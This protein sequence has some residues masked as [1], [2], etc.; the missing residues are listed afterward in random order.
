MVEWYPVEAKW[1]WSIFKITKN[2]Y[3]WC[4]RKAWAFSVQNFTMWQ[5]ATIEITLILLVH[6]TYKWVL[7]FM[8][9]SFMVN[10]TFNTMPT[11][12]LQP[13]LSP[14][15]GFNGPSSRKQS[16]KPPQIEIWNTINEWNYHFQNVKPTCT[17]VKLPIKDFLMTV[18]VATHDNLHENNRK[19]WT[20]E[21]NYKM[22]IICSVLKKATGIWKPS[23]QPVVCRNIHRNY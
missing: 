15:E 6:V 14:R 20:P 10:R 13:V 17:N 8:R 16:S 4:N 9:I 1:K 19:H 3:M 5:Q 7:F 21:N 12:R 23:P 18:L 11:A 2:K 22:H